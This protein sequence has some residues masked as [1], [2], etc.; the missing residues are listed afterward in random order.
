MISYKSY[1]FAPKASVLSA[2]S[3]F[4]SFLS[5]IGAICLIALG[6]QKN[7]VL[8]LVGVA[9]LALAA[10]LF[11]VVYRKIVFEKARTETE[12]NINTKGSFAAM[13]CNQHPEAYEQLM[14]INPDFA[15]RYTKNETGKIVKKK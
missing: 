12:T 8:I 1:P 14:Q 7:F 11:L 3:A 6:V 15:Q 4:G 5:L 10:F 2:L 9:L 13:Y